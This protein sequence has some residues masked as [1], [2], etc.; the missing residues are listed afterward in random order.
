MYVCVWENCCG[1][2]IHGTK[3]FYIC[4]W[5]DED[6]PH[7]STLGANYMRRLFAYPELLGLY[8]VIAQVS[9]AVAGKGMAVV[10]SRDFSRA[11]AKVWRGDLGR[12][13][14]MFSTKA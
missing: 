10:Q 8:L 3:V 9:F 11:R 13:M 2:F 12:Y 6:A 1:S 7:M 5:F 14:P 4:S